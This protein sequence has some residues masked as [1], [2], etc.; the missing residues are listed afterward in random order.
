MYFNS[1]LINSSQRHR[2]RFLYLS[3]FIIETY[4]LIRKFTIYLSLL[5][6]L[7]LI[8][9]LTLAQVKSFTVSKTSF[10]SSV[11]DD[12]SPVFYTNGIVFCSN[13]IGNA[14]VSIKSEDENLFNILFVEQKDSGSWKSPVLFS[15]ELTTILNE[16]PATF[17]PDRNTIY[18][19]RNNTIEGKL[20][21]INKPSN[22]LGIY[23]AELVNGIWK[24]IIAFP[25]NNPDYSLG[26]PAL[27]P[28]GNRIY[29]ASDM[30][31]GFGGSDIYYSDLK[32]GDWSEPVNM[33]SGINTEFDEAYPFADALGRVFFSSNGHNSIGGKDIFYT[34]QKNGKWI[35]PIHLDGDIN[36][37]DDD[38]GI[39][40]D[41]NFEY[42]YFSSDR[43]KNTDIYSFRAVVP[44][45]GSCKEQSGFEQCFKFF[46]ERFSDSLQLEH[47]WDFGNGI[48]KH[49][50]SVEQCFT[51]PG[52]YT[53]VLTILNHIAD[54]SYKIFDEYHFE[55][56]PVTSPFIISE[57]ASVVNS[58]LSFTAFEYTNDT[59]NTQY[60][61]DFGK[62]YTNSSTKNQATF[63]NAGAYTVKLG[64][65][66]G[67]NDEGIREKFCIS[68]PILIF[69]D[70]QQ[71]AAISN[72]KDEV[73]I[74]KAN[75]KNQEVSTNT[76]GIVNYY[77]GKFEGLKY[78]RL[79]SALDS[80]AK[81]RLDF[82]ENNNPISGTLSILDYYIELMNNDPELR[83][84]I[85][86]HQNQKNSAKSNK[87]QTDQLAAN[88][89]NYIARRVINNSRIT[90]TGYGDS[91]PV[92]DGNGANARFNNKRIELIIIVNSAASGK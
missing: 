85:A 9:S 58:P 15:Q 13:A 20:K 65:Q 7:L 18:F 92:S 48:K 77:I 64:L 38:F 4:S 40:T 42:G 49:G 11:G 75:P 73:D 3:I 23:R 62:G 53:A 61:W 36:S 82:D 29:F 88:I 30:P 59:V 90:C 37:P 27:A 28:D 56:K 63:E 43:K 25:Y 87:E 89:N 55:V 69:S 47:E 80:I 78:A 74:K 44:Q 22:K 2:Q 10:T 66:R 68:K 1:S 57:D 17:T 8:D 31:D 72:K 70:N 34:L 86:V 81:F 19:A 33:G 71:L 6:G 35:A 54:S 76:F 46:D 16:G 83:L 24:N 91:R 84:E 79:S 51:R 26:T 41:A 60:F 45:F 21:D 50:I 14:A 67:K 12:F 32:N 39:V 5:P 52:K